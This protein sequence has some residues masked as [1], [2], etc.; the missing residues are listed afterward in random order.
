VKRHGPGSARA[1]RWRSEGEHC[2]AGAP[3]A[4][5][6]SYHCDVD[7]VGAAAAGHHGVELLP[8]FLAGDGAVHGVGGDTLCGVH[9]GGVSQLGS[10]ADVVGGQG[11]GAAAPY[12]PHLQTTCTGQVEDDP[13]VAVFHPVRCADTQS[14]VIAGG[15]DQITGAGLVAVG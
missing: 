7:V 6:R 5:P 15:N 3:C 9:G 1:D 4:G 10:G 13:P 12:V 14:A 8:G 2:R 11:D